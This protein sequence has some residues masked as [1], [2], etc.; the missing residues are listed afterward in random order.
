MKPPPANAVC[1][2]PAPMTESEELAAELALQEM[3]RKIFPRWQQLHLALDSQFLLLHLVVPELGRRRQLPGSNL[4]VRKKLLLLRKLPRKLVLKRSNVVLTLQW[5]FACYHLRVA[6]RPK[7]S[8][9]RLQPHQW[10]RKRCRPLRLQVEL[11]DERFSLLCKV[12]SDVLVVQS[13]GKKND[14]NHW[15]IACLKK[16]T[17]GRVGLFWVLLCGWVDAGAHC[18]FP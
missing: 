2:G 14:P 8:W 4:G 5:K 7:A 11:L 6:L 16:R 1:T 9:C 10:R 3:L 12:S 17:F 15:I 13:T 18:S